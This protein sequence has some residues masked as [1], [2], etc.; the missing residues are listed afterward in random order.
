MLVVGDVNEKQPFGGR[1]RARA[2]AIARGE[3]L[4]D[5]IDGTTAAADLYQRADDVADHVTK[6]TVA[7]DL[8]LDECAEAGLKACTTTVVV[9]TFRSAVRANDPRRKHFALGRARIAAGALKSREV[10]A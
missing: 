3:H 8:V 5:R 1:R 6:K 2:C 7:G 4:A 10:V 9:R